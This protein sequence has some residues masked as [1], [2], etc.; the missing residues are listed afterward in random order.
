MIEGAPRLSRHLTAK[1]RAKAADGQFLPNV[2][3]AVEG[4][5]LWILLDNLAHRLL[6]LVPRYP[7]DWKKKASVYTKHPQRTLMLE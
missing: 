5:L 3:W 6:L 1:H 2:A 4:R 7:C